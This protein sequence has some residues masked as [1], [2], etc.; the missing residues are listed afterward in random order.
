[1]SCMPIVVNKAKPA[2]ELGKVNFCKMETFR[3]RSD[4]KNHFLK[5]NPNRK[6]CNGRFDPVE[7]K[8]T[9][10][11]IKMVEFSAL[12]LAEIM[13]VISGWHS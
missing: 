12:A 4:P 2:A 11:G 1:M 6:V 7:G 9:H 13:I 3:G 5:S 10:G 8:I